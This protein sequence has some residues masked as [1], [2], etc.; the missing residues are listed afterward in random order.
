MM[1]K[2]RARA[3]L[4]LGLAGG[5][6]D[7][8]PYC[9]QYG[10]QV[11]NA[12]INHYAYCT[13]EPLNEALVEFHALD[14]DLIEKHPAAPYLS[15]ED[16]LSL[17][18]DTYNL[19]VERF[20]GGKSLDFRMFTRSD[21]PP[22]SGLGSSST[23]VVA[24]VR[25]YCEWLRL[26]LGEY[27]VARFAFEVER[28]RLKQ[29]GGRQDQYAAAFG[30]V[31]FIEFHAEE[32]VL[33]NPLRVKS[34]I[35]N[36]FESSLVLFDSSISRVSSR[37]IEEQISRVRDHECG[38]IEAT[39]RLKEDAMQMKEA[40]L[41]GDMSR[42]GQVLNRSWE[43]KKQLASS[44]S[45]SALDETIAAARKA[46]ALAAKISGAGGGGFMMFLV[47]PSRRIELERALAKR[48]GRLLPFRFS[49][50]GAE[51]WAVRE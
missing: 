42:I 6:T 30:G 25:A 28:L 5:G 15:P 16:G 4:R 51:S 50:E 24:M 12:T 43:S 46:G 32:R 22:G 20:N 31:N 13:I 35:I 21:A 7:V 2:F 38:A 45:S 44:I 36:E 26:P 11:L 39:H 29:T 33:V 1:K 41:K 34:W 18:R 10:G 3:P 47:E 17:H 19:V 8:S 40:L 37:I 49:F 14:V 9:D 23:L 27:D 48:S